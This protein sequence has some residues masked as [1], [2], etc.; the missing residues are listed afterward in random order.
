MLN[1]FENLLHRV[2][3]E[4]EVVGIHGRDSRNRPIWVCR[5]LI[6]GTSGVTMQHDR[7]RNGG[8][9]C[10]SS[11]C[12]KPALKPSTPSSRVL[13]KYRGGSVRDRTAFENEC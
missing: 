2:F 6:C 10:P 7:L 11:I 1:G 4:L 3:N 13:P 5:C 9:R 8:A 12:G